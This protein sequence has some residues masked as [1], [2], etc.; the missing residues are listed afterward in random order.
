MASFPV[1]NS[2]P[3]LDESK[4]KRVE[5]NENM[6]GGILLYAVSKSGKSRWLILVSEIETGRDKV[7]YINRHVSFDCKALWFNYNTELIP[8]GWGNTAAYNFY[9]AT[10]EQKKFIIKEMT[11]HGIRY[12][13]ALNRLIK[14]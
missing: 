1:K 13:K 14:R 5:P 9:I 3:L 8:Q 6:H 7:L 4:L 10:P 11:S 12:V 2:L